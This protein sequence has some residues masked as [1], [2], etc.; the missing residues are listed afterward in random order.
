MGAAPELMSTVQAT[1]GGGGYSADDLADATDDN[2]TYDQSDGD[3]V[4]NGKNFR[5]TTLIVLV[6]TTEAA[7]V[8]FTV[9]PVNPPAGVSFNAAGTQITIDNDTLPAAWI[10]VNNATVRVTSVGGVTVTSQP[11]Q[12]QP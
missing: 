4:I 10:S 3:L 6:P 11:I 12:T 1:F 7:A 8:T 5:S 2:G 9:D